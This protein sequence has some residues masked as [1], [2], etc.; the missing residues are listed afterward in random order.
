MVLL[1]VGKIRV[2]VVDDDGVVSC[3][4]TNQK[5]LIDGNDRIGIIMVL[6]VHNVPFES[7]CLGGIVGAFRL[8]PTLSHSFAFLVVGYITEYTTSTG[9]YTHTHTHTQPCSIMYDWT[10]IRH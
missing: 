2:G 1:C 6:L 7:G 5:E 3:Q 10:R 8:W 4:P 9:G